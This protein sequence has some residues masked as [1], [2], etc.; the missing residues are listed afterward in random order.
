MVSR[1]I[2]VEIA[3]EAGW[4][5]IV[6]AG[7]VFGFL[8]ALI[9]GMT[10]AGSSSG[11]SY[12]EVFIALWIGFAAGLIISMVSSIMALPMIYFVKW[13]FGNVPNWRTAVC[14]F[15]GL[16][17]FLPFSTSL[18]T[19]YGVPIF[20]GMIPIGSVIAIFSMMFGQF[21]AVFLVTS[22]GEVKAGR[23]G[24]VNGSRFQ[25]RI[26]HILVLMIWFGV[27]LTADRI[28]PGHILLSSVIFYLVAQSVLVFAD[29]LWAKIRCKSN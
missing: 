2:R 17:G 8:L 1:Q 4:M 3:L 12:S 9:L 28:L 29:L 26:R 7:G 10:S 21:G 27:I 20:D 16:S 6:F 5:G 11:P 15:G 23:T 25:F 19:T 14:C 24:S 22:R 18:F 13:T